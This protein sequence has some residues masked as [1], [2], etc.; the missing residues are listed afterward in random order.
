MDDKAKT[1]HEKCDKLDLSLVLI[2][3][4]KDIRFGGFTTKSWKGICGNKKDNSAFVFNLKNNKI[5]DIIQMNLLSDII[6]NSGQY[7]SDAKLEFMMNSLLREEVLV[8]LD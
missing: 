5:Y 4:D 8:P 3:T 6:Q 1:F 7:F 2:E